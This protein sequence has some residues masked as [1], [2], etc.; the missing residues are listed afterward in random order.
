VQLYEGSEASGPR[1]LLTQQSFPYI[2]LRDMAFI[3][4]K[5]SQ[6]PEGIWISIDSENTINEIDETNNLI[7]SRGTQ[8][9][10]VDLGSVRNIGS[11]QSLT[12]TAQATD[13]DGT[14]IV[15]YKWEIGVDQYIHKSPG[16]P[17]IKTGQ[18]ITHTFT[19]EGK[20]MIR[21]YALDENGEEGYD[22]TLVIVEADQSFAPEDLDLD[23]DVD[24]KDVELCIGVL[25]GKIF[26]LDVTARADVN[27]DGSIDVKDVQQIVNRS[28]SG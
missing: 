13:P 19:E 8:A 12:M 7:F 27:R 18:S 20:Y 10:Y 5:V 4:A 11:G 6:K 26:D 14:N 21:V 9:P 15:S 16:D 24:E 28:I 2:H 23:S 22:S 3:K 17:V 25:S 1:T